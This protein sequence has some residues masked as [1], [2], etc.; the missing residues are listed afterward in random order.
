MAELSLG[1]SIAEQVDFHIHGTESPACNVLGYDAQCCCLIVFHRSWGL[2][3]SH[4]FEGMACWD[5]FAE[6][7]EEGS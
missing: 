2:F 4:L 1:C 5:G 7:D 6:V 3:V